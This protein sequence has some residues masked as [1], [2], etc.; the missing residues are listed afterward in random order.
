[1]NGIEMRMEMDTV[2]RS[3]IQ[4]TVPLRMKVSL[5]KVAGVD[6]YVGDSTIVM[7]KTP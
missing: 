4:R 2:N 3:S 5:T 7:I 6:G 1:M